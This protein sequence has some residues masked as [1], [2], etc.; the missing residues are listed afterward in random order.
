MTKDELLIENAQLQGQI[1]RMQA[2]R[3]QA[4][5]DAHGHKLAGLT[6]QH[7]AEMARIDAQHW[8]KCF[9]DSPRHRSPVDVPLPTSANGMATV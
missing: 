7:E 9:F 6:Y 2:E 1:D 5:A 8:K 4:R 3:D